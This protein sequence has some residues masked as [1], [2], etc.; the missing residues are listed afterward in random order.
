M[1]DSNQTPVSDTNLTTNLPAQIASAITGIP[2][3]LVPAALKALDRLVGAVVDIPAA[4][5]N[6]QKAKIDAQTEAYRRVEGAIASA[7]ADAATDPATVQQA[8]NVLVRKEY[9]KQANR[10]A[11]AL[12][13]IENLGATEAD[14]LDGST[15]TDPNLPEA[16][17]DW[18]NVFERYAEDASS[19]RM[20]KLW[21]R[22]LAGEIRRPGRY[23][24]R[25]LRFLSEFSQVDALM[26]ETFCQNTFGDLAP[27]ALVQPPD[28][29]DIRD[30][31]FL[32]ANGLIQ[33]ASGLGLS[34]TMRFS[35]AGYMFLS[36]NN[37]HICFKGTPDTEVS[38][39]IV[40][41]TP[42]GQELVT[43]LPGRDARVVARKVAIAMRTP[44][45][46]EAYLGFSEKP[47]GP[48]MTMEILWQ[49]DEVSSQVSS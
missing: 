21:A 17:E 46:E 16:N 44:H 38:H 45:L 12:A 1:S 47:G 29:R 13:M 49:K 48:F 39:A 8:L 43:L 6:Q 7:A 23:A 32:E 40:L 3:A 24:M 28:R 10:Q 31:I 22:V 20:Q 27:K 33:G 18:L 9:R 2:H 30:L 15:S 37:L 36:E 11:V 4:W 41:L 25:T 26:F 35:D 42:L 5:L 14:S 19:E 34:R